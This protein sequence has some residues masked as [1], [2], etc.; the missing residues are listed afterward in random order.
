MP[1]QIPEQAPVSGKIK[2]KLICPLFPITETEADKVLLP[3]E[4]GDILILP[5]RAPIFLALRPGRML[6]YRDNAVESYLISS[7]VC[8]FRRNLCP[9]LAWGGAEDK[10]DP[11]QIALQLSLANEAIGTAHSFLSRTEIAAR[12][13]FFKMILQEKKYRAADYATRQDKPLRLSPEL[14]GGRSYSKKT[15]KRKA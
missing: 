15:E 5:D 2:V 14:F 10:I 8:E 12:I 6:I 11:H 7:G 13:E 9:V 1:E 3:A 4:G